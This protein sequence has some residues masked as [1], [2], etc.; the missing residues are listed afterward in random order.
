MRKTNLRGS[1][2]Q[3]GETL[4][5]NNRVSPCMDEISIKEKEADN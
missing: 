2:D 4:V 5:R 3:P 1:A